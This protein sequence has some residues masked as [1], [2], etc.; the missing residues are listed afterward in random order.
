[1]IVMFMRSGNQGSRMTSRVPGGAYS[2]IYWLTIGY[3]FSSM[4]LVNTYLHG[5]YDNNMGMKRGFGIAP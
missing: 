5:G 4:N 2:R 1:M 3:L